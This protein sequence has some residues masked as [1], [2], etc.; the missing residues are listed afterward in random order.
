[1]EGTVYYY[2]CCYKRIL[3]YSVQSKIVLIVRTH[4]C[5]AVRTYHNS[6]TA[7][8][9]STLHDQTDVLIRR[10]Q[11]TGEAYHT[12]VRRKREHTFFLDRC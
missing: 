11:E 7:V 4:H 6:T 9:Y 5:S 2:Y 12:A 3:L 1:M 8:F 10:E